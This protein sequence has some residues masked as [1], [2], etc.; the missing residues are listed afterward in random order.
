MTRVDCKLLDRRIKAAMNFTEA[1][2]VLKD[3]AIPNLFTNEMIKGDVAIVDGCIAGIGS[4]AGRETIDCS[5]QYVCPAFIDGH[6]HIES[7]LALPGEFAKAVIPHG[8]LTAIADPHE[9]ANVCGTAGIEYFIRATEQL[10]MRIYFM[11]PSCVPA[12]PQERNGAKLTAKDL[13]QLLSHP[14][15]LGL[16][17]VMDYVSVIRGNADMLRKICAFQDRKIDGHLSGV[18]GAEACAYAAT[19]VLTNHECATEED[20][21]TCLRLGMYIQIREGSAAKNLDMILSAVK[22]RGVCLDR[23]FFCTDDKN[24]AEIRREGHIVHNVRKAAAHGLPIYD[25]LRM[26]SLNAARCYGLSRVGAVAPGYR[27]DL[28]VISDLQR[29]SIERVI[30]N[31]KTVSVRGSEPVVP[32]A[33]VET[34]IRQTMRVA[35]FSPENLELRITNGQAKV[36]SLIPGQLINRLETA[37]VC[38][39]NGIFV[40]DSNFSKVAVAERHHAT[41]QIGL[42]IVRGFGI[43]KGAIASTIA[44]DS[45]N[46]IV[47]GDNDRDM[48]LAMEAARNSG[49]GIYLASQGELL[50]GLPLPIAG[51]MSD[52]PAAD[53]IDGITQLTELAHRCGVSPDIDP[54]G[55]L[56]FLA[57]PVIPEARITPDG[58]FNVAEWRVVSV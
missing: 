47:I 32:P 11:A 15:V 13:A 43:E 25:V 2:L 12:T 40:P 44:H 14:R 5:G 54:C 55:L 48:L 57:L 49:G 35:P 41:G 17:E 51:L 19:G 39:F 4:Y 16:G 33:P 18:F 50:G 24:L 21:L 10:P 7:T 58:L 36:I 45:H 42:G 6:V 52:R 20:V 29:F 26:A 23:L 22:R 30:Q 53:I 27:A 34:W 56:S 37:E 31:G 46:L 28:L 3:A 1:D 38:H 9:I 8:T